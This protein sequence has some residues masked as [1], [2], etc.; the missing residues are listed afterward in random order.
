M[1]VSTVGPERDEARLVPQLPRRLEVVLDDPNDKNLTFGLA[2]PGGGGLLLVSV[3]L[4]ALEDSGSSDYLQ[5]SVEFAV[6][7]GTLNPP[8]DDA[9]FWLDHDFDGVED[10]LDIAGVQASL[11]SDPLTGETIP[12]GATAPTW[13]YGYYN[14]ALHPD[15]GYIL[16]T[17]GTDQAFLGLVDSVVLSFVPPDE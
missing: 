3:G 5:K 8:T 13:W 2:P 12:E 9:W 16:Q 1:E 4:D 6:N 17:L 11:A 7:A 14:P 15:Y 10:L